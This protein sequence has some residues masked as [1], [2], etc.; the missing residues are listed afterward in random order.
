M[1]SISSLPSLA[2]PDG[3]KGHVCRWRILRSHGQ[4]GL[5]YLPRA[6]AT[7]WLARLL[8]RVRLKPRLRAPVMSSGAESGA[9]TSGV[10][11]EGLAREWE[12]CAEIRTRFRSEK[13][14]FR[15][16]ADLE[17]FVCKSVAN[18]KFNALLMSPVAKRMCQISG[19]LPTILA[20]ETEI[21]EVYLICNETASCSDRV[22]Y[23]Q[24][25]A[26]RRLAQLLKAI[27]SN[28]GI[29]RAPLRT[30]YLF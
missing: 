29:P 18:L 11:F 2:S 3:S 7:R 17:G 23:Q 30:Q 6:F 9:K 26:C 12:S 4:P 24:S 13:V 14:L 16:A 20:V 1:R 21:K 27:N 8:L 15:D 5:V 22:L 19:T 10:G 28:K 25:W